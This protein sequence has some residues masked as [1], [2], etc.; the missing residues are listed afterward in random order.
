M[1]GDPNSDADESAALAPSIDD[2]HSH[3]TTEQKSREDAVP[4]F[5]IE[6]D[7]VDSVSSTRGAT[8]PTQHHT[9][10]FVRFVEEH[11]LI[12]CIT[13]LA[14]VT[15]NVAIDRSRVKKQHEEHRLIC[16]IFHGHVQYPFRAVSIVMFSRH[17][18]SRLSIRESKI[19]K[20]MC[21]VVVK[22]SW[23]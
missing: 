17:R 7:M 18:M 1:D 4:N 15:L 21:K 16:C 14:K 2:S 6:R 8:I 19:F 12:C 5:A 3:I 20:F 10:I 22:I 11:R 13:L 9:I 23:L